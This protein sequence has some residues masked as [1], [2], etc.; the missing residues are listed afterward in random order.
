M[1]GAG[2]VQW[3][4][5][6][7]NVNAWGESST[8]PELYPPSLAMEQFTVN[9]L[10]EMGAQ[11]SSLEAGLI[12]GTQST[13]TTPPSSTITSPK[14]NETL[15]EGKSTTIT[16]TATDSGGGVVAGVEVSTDNGASWHP[17]TL[18]TADE[19]TVGWT[20]TWSP[21]HWPGTTIKS[22]AVDDSNNVETPSAGV[23][24]KVGCPCSIWGTVAPTTPV[25]S[26]PNSI[27][28][29]VKFTAEVGGTVAGVRFYKA[30]TD[31]GTHVGS[32]WSASG[33]L[34]ASATFSNETSSGWQQ[35]SFSKPVSISAGT[36]YVA[37]YLAPSGHYE[38]SPDYFYTPTGEGGQILNSPPLHAV[39]ASSEPVGGAFGSANGVFNYGSSSVFPT[40]SDEGANYWVDVVFEPESLV[41]PGQVTKVSATAG[42]GSATVNWT[43][44]ST[45]GTPTQYTITPYIGKTAQTTT[46]VTAPATSATVGGLTSG[47]SYT[48]TVTASNPTGSGP[49]SEASN[50]VTPTSATAPAAPTEV[51]AL[52]G[53]GSASVS[54]NAPS[55]DGSPITKYTVT[56][57]IGTA[58]QTATSVSGTPPATSVTVNG[59]TNGTS[60]TFKV[61][62]TNEIGQGP[63]SS[64][65]SA[66]TPTAVPDTIFGT[67]AP[68]TVDSGDPN[69]VELGVKF[70]SEVA[71]TVTGVRFYKATTNTGTHVGSLWSS[72]GT[73]LASATF[74]SETASGWQQVSFSKPVAITANTTYVAAY[75][76]PAGHYSDTEPGFTDAI[77]NPP[78][79]ALSHSTSANGVYAYSSSSVFPSNTYKASNYWVDVV[80]EPETL[81]A[82]GQVTKVSATAGNGSALVSWSAPTSGGT[83]TQYTVTPYVGKTAQTTVTVTGTPPATSVTVPGLTSG[84]SYT[85]TV[86]ASDPAG[87]GPASEPSNAVIPTSTT[88]PSAPTEVTAVAGSGS[89]SVSWTAPPNG[90]SQI[91][92]YTVTPYVGSAPQTPT[93]VSG[94]PPATTTTVNGLANGTSYTFVVSATNE[95]GEGPQ[96]SAS[97]AVTPTLAPDT[98]FGSAAPSTP[99]SGDTNSVELGMKFSSEV[100]GAVTGVRFYK[101]STN[102][103]THVG[104]LWSASGTLLASATFTNET[105]S[106]W[107]QVSFSKPVAITANTTYVAAY[108]APNGHYSDTASG[109]T[110]A[111]TNPPLIGLSN[112]T[113]ANGVYTYTSTSVFP[114][115]SY[116]STNYWVDVLFEP[117]TVVAPGQV[118]KVSATAGKGSATVSWT[119]PASGG[120]PT[121]YT[122][123][124]YIGNAAQATTTVSAPATSATVTGLSSGASYTFTVTASDSAGAG[125][126]SEASNA[127]TPTS[128]TAPTAPTEVTAV[129]GSG[130]ATVSWTAP[131]NGGSQISKYTVTPYVG[132][133]AHTA[134]VVSGAPP[135]TSATVSGLTNG[136][137]YTFKVSA[138][139]EI[140]EGP[141]SSASSA[142]T[143]TAAPETIFGSATPTTVDSGDSNSVELGVKFSSELS[144][145]I[146]GVRFY[147]AST[148][149][150]THIGSLWSSTGTLLASATFTNETSSGWQQV[151]F[152]KAVS[153]TANTT[154]VAGYL[155]PNGHYSDTPSGFSS[156]VTSTPL[157][158]LAN[159]TSANG[160]Y[161]YSSSSVFPT[162]TYNSTNY[163]VDVL[164]EEL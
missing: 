43:A 73:L 72:T 39:S 19:Q 10:A 155:A 93:V 112:S 137:S 81:V 23:S 120:T 5:G 57:Y 75:F 25:S 68:A 163:W 121:Q 79:T 28:V 160:V 59:L 66:V 1:F 141:Q 49:V 63:Q 134:T 118:T 110:S 45:G 97:S 3:S 80:F 98:L 9:L 89:A 90:G 38:Q 149:T 142:V 96:S 108:L 22:R 18:T 55:N 145:F 132:S 29:G 41:V 107:Q 47:T 34:L 92:K 113:S 14:A 74:S 24:V 70:S 144:G 16:G 94:T 87:S 133:T 33:T 111:I 13:D 88:A 138:T 26:D 8:D 78:L 91:T 30:T 131:S 4:W 114:G 162:N 77:T 129:A 148:N 54:W 61:S 164:F 56:P 44:P 50:A 126:A 159:G 6:L 62:A 122:I 140:G 146:T 58:A 105:S 67:S 21:N 139:N 115:S 153:I 15:A 135:T 109:F 31:T 52:A 117:E 17:A 119:A 11:P 60:Y 125:P 65:S 127:I 100:S 69:P 151:T 82:P 2:T 42:S 95:I 136:T 158:A 71:G 37:G 123:T 124:P 83:P 116:K 35:V 101:A 104:S 84:T 12:A 128:A 53:S 20:Y 64:A 143:P 161:A 36:T 85:F 106:G 27:T 46:T 102:T 86:T 156:A 157:T 130:S 154:Y 32:L 40:T 76:A 99:D 103:G 147:K 48:F 152:S 7:E 51:V 150:G